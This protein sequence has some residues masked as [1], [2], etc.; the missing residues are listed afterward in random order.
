[1]GEQR[2]N[3]V[4]SASTCLT[5]GFSILSFCRAAL[6]KWYHLQSVG[7]YCVPGVMLR[8][9]QFFSQLLLTL[10]ISAFTL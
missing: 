7:T 8:T 1:M 4:G 3:R 6:G 5:T 9:L 10:L 2:Q